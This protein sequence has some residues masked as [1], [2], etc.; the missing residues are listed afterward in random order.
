MEHLITVEASMS[1]TESAQLSG[2]SVATCGALVRRLVVHGVLRHEAGETMRFRV[3]NLIRHLPGYG[4]A[5]R[6]FAAAT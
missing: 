4:S 1:I 5:A 3:L 2:L 6:R